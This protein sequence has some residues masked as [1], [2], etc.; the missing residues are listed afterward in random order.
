MQTTPRTRTRVLEFYI[1]EYALSSESVK[2]ALV[3]QGPQ[4][5]IALY[6]Y[7]RVPSRTHIPAVCLTDRLQTAGVKNYSLCAQL[8]R[9]CTQ[10]GAATTGDARM[11]AAWRSIH[12]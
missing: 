10:R 3:D 6:P 4:V 1:P 8:D 9:G 5:P 7:Y 2:A 12:R 11:Q